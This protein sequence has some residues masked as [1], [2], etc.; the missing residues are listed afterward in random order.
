MR[1]INRPKLPPRPIHFEGLRSSSSV[2]P[3]PRNMRWAIVIGYR[4]PKK[5]EYY[6][7]GAIVEAYK[8]YNDL[9]SS[10]WVVEPREDVPVAPIN[11]HV[12][13]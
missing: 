9:T 3:S 6:L 1:T 11:L 13:L 8:A 4:P 5:G 2:H 10:Y 12:Y 7:G